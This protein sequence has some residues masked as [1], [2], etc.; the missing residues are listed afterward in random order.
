MLWV[1]NG[2]DRGVV[3]GLGKER[4]PGER[5]QRGACRPASRGREQKAASV[6]KGHRWLYWKG[7]RGVL[8]EATPHKRRR[9]LEA[10]EG[11]RGCKRR[12]TGGRRGEGRTRGRKGR[13]EERRHAII[14]Y[15]GLTVVTVM[16]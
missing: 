4:W 5:E 14:M 1:M 8:C 16:L 13:G 10:S 9:S 11:R 3:F 2:S 7:V 12:V 6:K 15:D